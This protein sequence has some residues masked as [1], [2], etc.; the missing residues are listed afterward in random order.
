VV[1]A[2]GVERWLAQQLSHSLGS[3]AGDDGVCAGLQV[4]A[5]QSFISL[6]L[7]RDRD[8]PW[9]ADLLVWPTLEAIGDLAG[10]PHSTPSRIIPVAERRSSITRVPSVS[11]RLA[12]R[13]GTQWHAASQDCSCRPL[14]SGRSC[15]PTGRQARPQTVQRRAVARLTSPGSGSCGGARRARA[16]TRGGHRVSHRP[17][18]PRRGR[19]VFWR[20]GTRPPSA[21]LVGPARG[22]SYG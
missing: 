5:P 11:A 10:S 19:N 18:L 4:M 7:G 9:Q 6:L 16:R 2:R 21:A 13:A 20:L 17:S 15:L 12:S 1:P 14:G 8:D 3:M 22:A